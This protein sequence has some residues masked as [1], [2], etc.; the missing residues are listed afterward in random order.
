[1]FKRFIAFMSGLF[2]SPIFR[3][4]MTQFAVLAI[5][6]GIFAYLTLNNDNNIARTPI[7]VVPA[8]Y[9]SL[10]HLSAV[11]LEQQLRNRWLE[12]AFASRICSSQCVPT[13]HQ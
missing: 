13:V 11:D 12:G 1:M 2:K 9:A 3:R 8:Q 10:S 4:S 5:V 7:Q 6:T